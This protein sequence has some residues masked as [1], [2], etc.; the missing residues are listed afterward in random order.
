MNTTA[1]IINAG[2]NRGDAE[3]VTTAKAFDQGKVLHDL[4]HYLPS[5]TPIKDFIHHNS[6]HAFQHMKFYPAIFKAAKIFGYQVT[7][8]LKDFRKM[9]EQGRIRKEVVER[10]VVE[11]KGT[12]DAGEWMEKLLHQSY[13][14]HNEPRIGKLR[15]HW[16]S[17]YGFDMDNAVHPL[18]FRILTSY[19]DQGISLW[20]FPV[21]PDGLIASLSAIEKNGLSSFFKNKRSRQLLLNP[22]VDIKSLLEIIV[23]E[24]AYFEQY[25][26]DQQFAHPGW[27]G[28]VSAVEEAPHTLLDDR[29]I[30]LQELIILELLLEIDSLD[31]ALGKKWQPL[32]TITNQAPVDLFADVPLT[33]LQEVLMLWQDAF[34]WS[35]Y[36]EVLAG[37]QK[38]VSGK[39]RQLN[40]HSRDADIQKSFQA[41]FCID[42]REC[43]LR[44]HLELVDPTAETLGSPGFFGAEFYFQPQGGRFY[45]K[46]CPAPVTPKYLIKEYEVKKI[47]KHEFL[48]TRATH[49]LAGGFITSITLGFMSA[50]KLVQHLFSPKMSPAISN[51][52]G[53]M[54]NDSK[55]TIENTDPGNIENGLQVGFTIEEM[56]TR[57]EGTLRG[58][59]LVRD[60]A[61]LIYVVA[62]GSS[63]AN[64][65][66]HSAHDCGA[67]SGRPGSVNARVFAFMANHPSVRAI[68][69]DKG[70]SIPART[71]FIGSLHDTAADQVEFYDESGMNE[72]N[73][74]L[75]SRNREIFENALDLNARERSRRFASINTQQ[76]IKKIRKAIHNR[77]VSLFEPRPELGHGTNTLCIVGRRDL[78]KGLF[79]DRRAFLN[80]YDPSTDPEGKILTAVMRP[81]GLVCG[82]INLEYY[83][84]RVDNYKLGAG[85]KLP[86][87]VVGLVGVAN[88]SDGDLRPGLP[89]QMI[90]VHD[91]VRLL[92]IVEHSPEIVLKAITSAPEIFEWY[93]NEWVHIMAVEPGTGRYYYF[94]DGSFQPYEPVIPG[95]DHCHDLHT[96]VR[97]AKEMETN[98]IVD[99]T[100]E[101]LPVYTYN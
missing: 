83:F 60:F 23:G 17:Y 28:I 5:Q 2:I 69:K 58:I 26:F 3:S 51:A 94:R 87:N 50:V 59:G 71:Q 20:K 48:Y 44:R 38:T 13:D 34:E 90:E 46:L 65:P 70:I 37:M 80:S 85:T 18:L 35:Y 8:E 77:S 21:H 91:P 88:S 6:L 24:E 62:H 11:K 67:C 74:A 89:L 14:T 30:S 36:D 100:K 32:S 95:V 12:E 57:V 42:E 53:H 66:H 10:L 79:L 63:S 49:T 55:L 68:L 81:I 33:E 73:S 9:Y 56:A 1:E 61:P 47:K 96:L 22:Q 54:H 4:K 19:L 25:L 84:S 76:P 98:H 82:G 29:N 78:T 101:N 97:S 99:A 39:N 64:N 41:I 86:H 15:D 27:S 93:N 52:F 16:K 31:S 75:H 45:E 7:L 92:V 40:G 72:Q 43:S